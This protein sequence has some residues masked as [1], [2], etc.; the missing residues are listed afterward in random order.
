[1]T[2]MRCEAVR[3]SSRA[4]GRRH[5]LYQAQLPVDLVGAIHCK[6]EEGRLVERGQ[7]NASCSACVRGLRG[8]HV[9]TRRPALT[10][11]PTRSTN[12]A[13]VEPVPRP[14]VMLS[15]MNSAPAR[16]P[17]VS[18]VCAHV[19]PRA[20]PPSG[21]GQGGPSQAISPQGERAGTSQ[22]AHQQVFHLQEFLHPML[23]A[24]AADAGFFDAAEWSHLAG[25]DAPLMRMMPHSSASAIRQTRPISRA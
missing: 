12:L 15:S 2:I 7:R 18:G 1:M 8:R 20:N 19:W 5:R 14:S 4:A 23:G 10:R 22:A 6:I 25:D 9:R 17:A 16:R 21:E 24:L 3:R 13:A 11:C